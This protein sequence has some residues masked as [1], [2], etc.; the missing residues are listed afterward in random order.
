MA[1]LLGS[2]EG[3]M[4]SATGVD[5]RWGGSGVTNGFSCIKVTLPDELVKESLFLQALHQLV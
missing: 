4:Q 3:G 5:G 1:E 2:I